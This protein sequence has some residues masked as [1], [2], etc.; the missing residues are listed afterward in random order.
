MITHAEKAVWHKRIVAETPSFFDTSPEK[1]NHLKGQRYDNCTFG[2]LSLADNVFFCSLQWHAKSLQLR[3]CLS[4]R[5]ISNNEWAKHCHLFNLEPQNCETICFI[6]TRPTYLFKLY[7]QYYFYGTM[8][9]QKLKIGV[10]SAF[11]TI[12]NRYWFWSVKTLK[13][14]MP[15]ITCQLENR[16]R[17]P[18]CL[19]TCF[20][21]FTWQ[22]LTIKDHVHLSL[23]P[24]ANNS[25]CLHNRLN[26]ALLKQK[27]LPSNLP[28]SVRLEAQTERFL[29]SCV[30]K[31][32]S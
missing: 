14:K 5:S 17:T 20:N 28:L 1:W 2:F 11:W 7:T 27:I 31:A 30:I 25:V 3:R 23:S 4:G 19:K 32:E 29:F 16:K 24:S 6:W 12:I 10:H 22:K 9:L 21:S 8:C 26:Y 15:M 18:R 13:E